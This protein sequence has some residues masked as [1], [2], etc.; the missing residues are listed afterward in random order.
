MV[1]ILVTILM[2]GAIIAI[3]EF[4]H[5]AAAKFFGVKVNEFAIGMGPALWK[6]QSGETL[7]ALRALPI[8]GYCAMEGEDES[9]DDPR[10]FIALASWKKIIVLAAG[11]FMNFVLGVALC[12]GL[13]MPVSVFAT[14]EIA[15]LETTFPNQGADGLMAGDRIVS[16]D[17]QPIFLYADITMFFGRAE[18]GV[19]DLV[20]ERDGGRVTLNQ[21]PL[22]PMEYP[23]GEGGTTLRYGINFIVEEATLGSKLINGFYTAIDFVRIVFISL[24]DLISGAIGM[25]MISGP[26]GIVDVVSEAGSSAPTTAAAAYN[27]IY[28]AALITVNL[29]VMNLLPL[30][31]LD[32]GRIFFTLLNGVTW[33]VAKRKIPAQYEGAVHLIGM[34]LLLALT[35]F[36]TV[37]DIGKLF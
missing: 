13:M 11:A 25:D 37:S 29:A 32:G 3:H 6:K 26:V 27:I 22:T 35:V 33:A 1:Y 23:N 16:I 20:V 17:G 15:S 34:V 8:G 9:S 4:G 21:F 14:P 19:M 24:Q 30:P 2:F 18:N 7:Y 5:F 36:V 10:S 31:A 12:V 28:F